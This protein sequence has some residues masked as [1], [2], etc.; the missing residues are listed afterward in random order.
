M[1]NLSTRTLTLAGCS[2][3]P[4]L[5]AQ[6]NRSLS[7][8]PKGWPRHTLAFPATTSAWT[9]AS[10]GKPRHGMG[11]LFVPEGDCCHSVILPERSRPPRGGVVFKLHM[12]YDDLLMPGTASM[13][14]INVAVA[15]CNMPRLRQVATLLGF[16]A[17]RQAWVDCVE[18]CPGCTR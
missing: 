1:L 17:E 13:R 8:A 5:R 7:S 15:T 18:K 14:M 11:L 4:R 2:S 3:T 16:S 10:S 6:L 12:L 9:R